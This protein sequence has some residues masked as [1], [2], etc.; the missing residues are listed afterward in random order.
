[1]RIRVK[2]RLCSHQDSRRTVAAL[3]CS[4]VCE[5]ILQGMKPAIACESFHGEDSPSAA[6]KSKH[7]TGNYRLAIQE[8]GAR[9][10]FAQLAT[11]LRSGVPEIFPQ[12]F[13]QGFIGR[14]GNINL[15]AV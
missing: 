8:N 14:E 1:M 12:N 13:Q 6:L 5:G 9:T 7:Q 10:A 4:K 3:R 11:V 15:L 2:Q